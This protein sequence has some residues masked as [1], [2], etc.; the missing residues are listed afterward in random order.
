[1][2]SK[3]KQLENEDSVYCKAGHLQ[4]TACCLPQFQSTHAIHT[5]STCLSI[6]IVLLG[7]HLVPVS[8]I[9]FQSGPL[10]ICDLNVVLLLSVFPA[11]YDKF[12]WNEIIVY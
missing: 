1:M 8:L 2:H 12:A 11:L 9:M 5:L 3:V 10:L 7:Y 6:N 4:L